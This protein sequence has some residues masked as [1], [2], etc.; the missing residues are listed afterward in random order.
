M[1]KPPYLHPRIYSWI[2]LLPSTIPDLGLSLLEDER[3]PLTD[4]VRQLW[5]Q[6]TL[7]GLEE[8]AARVEEAGREAK[9][10]KAET[11][12]GGGKEAGKPRELIE[13][14]KAETAAGTG[15]DVE[16]FCVV[17]RRNSL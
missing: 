6:S 13:A 7:L 15:V 1:L 5:A 9:A 8:F 12:E 2:P 4:R 17:A 14:F 16:F 11:E 10:E 3:L